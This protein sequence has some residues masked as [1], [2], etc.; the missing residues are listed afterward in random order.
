M[1]LQTLEILIP[2]LY[3]VLFVAYLFVFVRSEEQVGFARYTKY[4]TI[5]VHTFYLAFTGISLGYMPFAGK[6][7]FLSLT[8]LALLIVYAAIEKRLGQYKTGVF[9]VGIALV[10]AATSKAL[11]KSETHSL[12]MENPTYGVHVVFMVLGFVSLALGAIY[13]LMYVLLQRQL[14]TKELGVFF[15][16]LPPLFDLKRMSYIGTIAGVALLAF[17]MGLGFLLALTVEGFDLFDTKQLISYGV[18]SGYIL[19]ILA[20]KF[21]G[22]SGVSIAYMTI[23]WFSILVV[24][25]GLAS[26][27]F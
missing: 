22:F 21:R 1:F 11:P 9:F 10:L 19:G 5:T 25:I 15:K 6:A 17:G 8:A 13:S 23:G 18:I 2:L 7:E 14:K 16:R 12:L 27:T 20:V 4:S 24:S 26:H 3:C